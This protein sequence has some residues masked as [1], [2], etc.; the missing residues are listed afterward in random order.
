MFFLREKSDNVAF[1]WC[2]SRDPYIGKP[3]YQRE[4]QI[5]AEKIYRCQPTMRIT[6]S[7]TKTFRDDILLKNAF[8]DSRFRGNDSKN[9]LVSAVS[10]SLGSAVPSA[11]SMR[12]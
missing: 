9:Y 12:I 3:R 2:F 5:L 11:F 7:P 10:W 1:G 6:R 4:R 8:L